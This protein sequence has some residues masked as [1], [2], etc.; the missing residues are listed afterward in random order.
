MRIDLT[1]SASPP[2]RTPG[3]PWSLMIKVSGVWFVGVRML[4]GVVQMV[5]DLSDG[6]SDDARF[7]CWL[8]FVSLRE[9][10]NYFSMSCSSSKLLYAICLHF[11]VVPMSRL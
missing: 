5:Q 4:C 7:W 9:A 6:L 8:L 2:L 10:R 1:Q 3:N 11:V